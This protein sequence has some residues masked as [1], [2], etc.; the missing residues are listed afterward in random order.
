MKG[1]LIKDIRLL[2]QQKKFFAMVLLIMVMMV[3]LNQD[4]FSF[5]TG[6]LTLVGA[7]IIIAT[8]AYDENDN[9][10]VFLMTLPVMRKTYV[11]EKYMISLLCSLS[12]WMIGVIYV[13]ASQL[14]LG[15]AF[16]L[17]DFLWE[18]S[19][20]IPGVSLLIAVMIPFVLKFGVEKGRI[21]IVLTAGVVGALLCIAPKLGIFDVDF[22]KWFS[23]FDNLD[24]RKY[25]M[26]LFFL[27]AALIV[28]I[29]YIISV[30][31]MKRKEY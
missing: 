9:S 2:L 18:M 17:S 27:A 7:F 14:I 26:L 11:A 29:S 13:S 8:F 23:S 21:A 20:M 6:Y 10:L 24:T 12:G 30:G 4:M 28:F 31:I 25:L 5:V 3:G 16:T 15:H 19:G 22:V 1:L